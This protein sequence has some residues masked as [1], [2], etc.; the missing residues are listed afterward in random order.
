MAAPYIIPNQ[1][2][3]IT[4]G[5]YFSEFISYTG[6]GTLS[7]Y[8]V[9]LPDGLTLDST[10]G[11]INGTPIK[12]GTRFAYVI[13]TNE[14]GSSASVIGFTIKETITS[15][16]NLSISPTVGYASST[17]YQFTT[18]ISQKLSAYSLLWNFGDNGT[19]DEENPIHIYDLPGNY[20]VSLFANI[21]TGIISLSA[22][23]IVNLLLSESI[24]FDFVP[25]PTFAGHYNRYPFKIN[26]TSSEEGPHYIDLAAQFSRSYENQEPTNKWSFLRPQWRFLDLNGNPIKSI[27]PSET[28]LYT[29]P[30]GML[31]SDN[32]GL[33]VGV[34]GS[35]EFYFVDDIYNYDLFI[36]DNPYTTIIATLR[37]SGVRSFNDSFNADKKLPGFS[38]SLAT[39]SCPY[40]VMVRPPDNV[41]ISENGIKFHTNP[42][43]PEAQQPVLI[44]TN[45][46][47]P[48]PT[49]Y[50]W[51]DGS[52]GVKI[53]NP[54]SYFCHSIPLSDEI[55]I[56]AGTIGISSNFIPTPKQF[57]WIDET[58]YKTPGYYK[59]TFFTNTVS[60]LNALVTASVDVS[61]PALSTQYYNP[62]LWVSNPEAGLMST[63][64]Y[65]YNPVLSAAMDTD[66]MSMA[67]TKTFEMP[68]INDDEVDFSKD[69][70][71]LSGIHGIYSIAAMTFPTYHAWA[72]D[73][74][75]NNLYRLSTNGTILCSIDINKLV[76]DNKLG[77]WSYD[78]V[79]P[80]SITLDGKQNIWLTL[81]DTIS[82]I[83]LDRYGNFL[84]AVTP[85]SATG[86]VFPPAP[87]IDGPWYAQT[88]YYDYDESAEYDW[89][90][91]NNE[92]NNFIEP[93]CIDADT[94]DNVWVTY[95][96]F[97]SGYLI[98]YD[99]NGN[100]LYSHT[101][102]VCSCPQEIVVDKDDNVWIALSNNI[103]STREC[104]LEKRNSNGVLLSS[105]YPIKG[106]NYLTLDTDQNP[107]F[108]FSYSWIG[109][110]N[111]STGEISTLNLLGTNQTTYAADWFDPNDNTDETALEGI[112]CDA[113]GRVYV[114]NSI[115]NQ[116]YVI[117]NKE[118][119]ILNKFYINPQGFTFYLEDQSSPTVMSYSL[120]NKSL[121]ATGDWTGFRWINKYGETRL[122]FFS[123]DTYTNTVTG[124]SRYLD[125]I[126]HEDYDFFKKNEDFD[127]AG[128]MQSIAFMPSL[129]ESKNLFESFLASIYGKYP[130][131][132]EDLGISIYEKISNFVLNHSDVDYCNINQLY[133]MAEKMGIDGEDFRLN[134]P[135]NVQR[136]INYAS[137]NQSRLLGARSLQEDS[138]T[139]LNN[140]DILNRG[141]LI[142][143]LCYK[144]SA[145][146]RLILKDRS[147]NKYKTIITGEING[148]QEYTIGVLAN[149]IGFTDSNWPSYY[150]FYEFV[151]GYDYKQ[152][153]GLIDW[154]NPQTT[155]NETLSTSSY[156]FGDEGFLDSE[157]SYGLY[158]GLGLI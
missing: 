158:K 46:V 3:N 117:D 134:F 11:Q 16:L 10:T 44:N 123:T 15:S 126:Q 149:F 119:S 83:K 88:S 50:E 148:C 66:N 12:V 133:D 32:R 105:V 69:A 153:E 1:S 54:D 111:N 85:L 9:G 86:Y 2:F 92:A 95:S 36:S 71:A 28:K 13:L 33:F 140:S 52:V 155:I 21:P 87:N 73:S 58:G 112:G 157:L 5:T 106:L 115:E 109:S 63:F 104:S 146:D 34:T 82:T 39:V 141:D 25:P 120:W 22:R 78:Q 70:M 103:W 20:I 156:W 94:Q 45:S 113:K 47:L 100:L 91:V 129:N 98:K 29:N 137:I 80:A 7:W 57:K 114:L 143:S 75:L 81:Y 43:W 124:Q 108:T 18:N 26:F 118:K 51:D 116:V 30:L 35:C 79:S 4:V 38:N 40:I 131:K 59:G 89:N 67:V 136:L 48:Y 130:F 23:I 102:P 64:Q 61:F 76:Y 132:H 72:L 138:F 99:S 150:E 8:A 107:W 77:F 151:P 101:Y 6:S 110:I 24:Y 37:T 14:D 74:E 27:V 96:Y 56:K 55:D 121:Q 152:L 154:E 60:S 68:V 127:M 147:I 31:D 142:T 19:S 144:V 97:A 65:I 135:P 93:T 42:R 41:K 139:T 17:P 122:P 125:F 128:Q 53:L 145:G 49:T 84:F 90:T 62:I